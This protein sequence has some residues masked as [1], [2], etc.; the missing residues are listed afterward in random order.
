MVRRKMLTTGMVEF[1]ATGQSF[2]G[3]FIKQEEVPYQDKVI[4]KYTFTNERGT[5][6]L[7]GGTQADEGMANA[8]IGDNLEIVYNGIQKT[9]NGF[10]VKLYDIF[11]LE[12]DDNNEQG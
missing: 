10:D 7:M 3:V 1:T 11:Q 2:V 9:S 8:T 4:Q 5:F 6:V 12:E